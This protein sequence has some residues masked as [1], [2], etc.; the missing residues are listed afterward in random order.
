VTSGASPKSVE[1]S[2]GHALRPE[3]VR[4]IAKNAGALLLAYILPRVLTFASVILAAWVLGPADFG[5]YGT[6]GAFAVILSVLSSLGML[7][8]LVRDIA[9]DP[10]S[11]PR[12][13]RAAHLI[14]TLAGVAMVVATVVLAR[15][16]GYSSEVTAASLLLVLG[17]WLASYAENLTAYFQGVE[18]MR[19][20]TEAS[21]AFG[22]LAGV[23]GALLVWSTHSLVWFSASLAIGHGAALAWLLSRVPVEVRRGAPVR[24]D[25]VLHLARAVLP[26]AVAFVLLTIHYKVD[27]LVLERM[28]TPAEVGNYTAAYKFVDIFHA[29]VV[30]GVAAVFP[31]L[32]RAAGQMQQ[33]GANGARWAA[34]RT[35]EVVLLATVPVG[36]SL[37][38]MR[39]Y[40]TVVFGPDYGEAVAA[41]AFIGPALPALALNVYGGYVLGA[42]RRMGWMAA[43]YACGIALKLTLLVLAAD[44]WGAVGAAGAMLGAEVA[45]ACAFL[46][47]LGRVAGAAPHSRPVLLAGLAAGL[48][49]LTATAFAGGPT[50][51]LPSPSALAALGVYLLAVSTLYALGGALSADERGAIAQAWPARWKSGNRTTTDS[52]GRPQGR[53]AVGVDLTVHRRADSTLADPSAD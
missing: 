14:K 52:A 31:R 3:A 42:A 9:R 45:L 24:R 38:L 2:G 27:V 50:R 26:F 53:R 34:T 15:V 16:L 35:T 23:A 7:P 5:H 17:Y 41:L 44:R 47:V 29:L 13:I 20:C 40:A 19:V 18:R 43:L 49:A 12:L 37:W 36:A 21:A 1:V 32:S 6:A 33:I 48:A 4:G 22:I 30:V 46:A 8:L 39:G 51:L 11:A 28:R 25:E 10:A